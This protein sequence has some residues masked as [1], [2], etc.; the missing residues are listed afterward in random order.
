[1][2]IATK[3]VII[4]ENRGLKS[5]GTVPLNVTNFPRKPNAYK[6]EVVS[7]YVDCTLPNQ[8]RKKCC[9]CTVRKLN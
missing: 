3:W 2:K 9:I 7:K 5:V 1:M 4:M 8:R 6:W